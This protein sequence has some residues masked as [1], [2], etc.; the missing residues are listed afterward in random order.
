MKVDGVSFKNSDTCE[1]V[2]FA[3]SEDSQDLSVITISG[4]YPESGWALNKIVHELVYI[5]SGAGSLIYKSGETIILEKG[6][7]V[8]VDPQQW[9]AWDGNMK[10]IMAC[11]PAFSPKQYKI[12]DNDEIQS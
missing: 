7:V 5:Q 9:F 2:S 8:A 6:D 11:Q 3:S 12:K 10:L 4:R 1:G